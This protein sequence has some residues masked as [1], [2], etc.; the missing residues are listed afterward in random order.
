MAVNVRRGAELEVEVERLVFGGRAMARH[1]GLVIF[2]EGG[3]P[4]Q[5]VVAEITRKKR[6]HAEARVVKVVRQS[7]DVVAPRCEH[8]GTCG[9][10]RW[11]HLD[12]RRQLYWKQVHVRECLEKLANAGEVAVKPTVG[13]PFLFGYRNKMEYT[14][15]DR[16]WLSA[17]EIAAKETRYDRHFA[18]GLHVR[19]FYNKVFDVNRCHLQSVQ[20]VAI[21]REVRWWCKGSGIPAYNIRNHQGC[22]RFLV[23]RDGKRSGQTLVHL[24]SADYPGIREAV[25]RL[26][27]HLRQVFPG[28]TTFIHSLSGKKAQVAIGDSSR[29]LWGEGV[30]EERLGDLRF[31]ISAHSFFQTNP[32]GAEKLYGTVAEMADLQGHERVWDLY[33]GTG[34]IAL[35]LARSAREVVG[36]EVVEDAIEDAYRNAEVNGIDNC[37]FRVGD[38]KD[39]IARA[40]DLGSGLGAPDLVVSDPPRAGMHPRVVRALL[41]LAPKRIVTVSCNPSTLARDLEL[42]QERYTI[43]DVQPFDLF[44]HTPHIECV[45]RLE[46]RKD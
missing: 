21:L 14:F 15:S 1:Q 43:A 31:R 27:E 11:Q 36:F 19:G 29:I 34:S 13:S 24:I 16:R 28:L 25:D 42:L 18:L 39:V 46:R 44:P 5:R 40:E 37:R 22:W 17:D 2:V 8:F 35:F 45:V 10:C 32:L 20:S 6:Q 12:Y 3:L 4:G 7:P 30:I 33:C 9:G 23:I 38:L 41:R 26:G